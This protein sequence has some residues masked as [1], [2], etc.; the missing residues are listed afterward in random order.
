[1]PASSAHRDVHAGL[2]FA[3]ARSNAGS[4]QVALWPLLAER[5]RELSASCADAA[6]E[7]HPSLEATGKRLL[8][9]AS[10]LDQAS[11][12]AKAAPRP[13]ERPQTA[14][15][16]PAVAVPASVPLGP[17]QQPSEAPIEEA[18]GRNVL[19][20]FEG[21]RCIHSRHCVLGAPGV[22]RANVKG[23]WL[24]PDG[25]SVE[26]LVA[27]AHDCPSGAITYDRL[28]GGPAEGPPPVNVIRIRENG[29]LAVHAKIELEGRGAMLRATLCRCGASKNKPYCDGSHVALSFVAS[30]EPMTQPSEPL[31]QRDGLLA[32]APTANGPLSVRGNVEV[33]SGTGRTVTR[34][35]QARLCRC[36]GSANKPFCDGTHARIGFRSG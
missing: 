24:N 9:L 22:F 3:M 20:R 25:A 35:S 10:G 17:G 5:T 12:V 6:K 7:V 15:P 21:K 16:P 28:D 32:I 14:T 29:P 27:I 34:V 18:R 26:E 11:P 8:E 19:L 30:G 23:A 4:E 31:V 13:R 1:M 33:C 36:G 2:S